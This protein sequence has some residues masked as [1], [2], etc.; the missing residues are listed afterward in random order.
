[1]ICYTVSAVFMF[2]IETS[3]SCFCQGVGGEKYEN[4]LFDYPVDLNF[5]ISLQ[6]NELHS[7]M[8]EVQEFTVIIDVPYEVHP[9]PVS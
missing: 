7:K 8:N 5:F 6:I 4:F 1:M 9:G 2:Q 3:D